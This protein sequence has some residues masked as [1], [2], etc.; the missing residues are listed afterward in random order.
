MAICG[1]FD[2]FLDIIMV[3]PI[4]EMIKAFSYIQLPG[5]DSF[6]EQIIMD[7]LY[8]GTFNKKD[9]MHSI[10]NFCLP[11]CKEK[12]LEII[13]YRPLPWKNSVRSIPYMK[14]VNEYCIDGQDPIWT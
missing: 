2:W 14:I 10:L 11:I 8:G 3:G 6:P 1:I 13:W 9:D 4:C 12:G 7:N 5:D